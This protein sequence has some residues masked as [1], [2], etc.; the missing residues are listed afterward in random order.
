MWCALT[1][2]NGHSHAYVY[3]LFA[4]PSVNDQLIVSCNVLIMCLVLYLTIASYVMDTI[5][6]FSHW[7]LSMLM[8]S[9]NNS[10]QSRGGTDVRVN[11]TFR[12]LSRG[13]LQW[14]MN[15]NKAGWPICDRPKGGGVMKRR[16]QEKWEDVW[17]VSQWHLGDTYNNN[18]INK[19][20]EWG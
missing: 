15:T 18:K 17:M 12:P 8:V 10:S 16:G 2:Q 14:Q 9:G 4:K 7:C 5:F 1:K 19:H 3:T 11:Q 6:I 20:V 13:L